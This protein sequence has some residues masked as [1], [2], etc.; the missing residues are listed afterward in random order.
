ME[1]PSQ[2]DDGILGDDSLRSLVL[3]ASS[4]VSTRGVVAETLDLAKPL[5]VEA[6]CDPE[7]SGKHPS[8][9]GDVTTVPSISIQELDARA[10]IETRGEQTMGIVL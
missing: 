6:L 4:P 1:R 2:G 10:N 9:C 7:G 8:L 3:M 5:E